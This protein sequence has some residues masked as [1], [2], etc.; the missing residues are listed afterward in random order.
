M[1]LDQTSDSSPGQFPRQGN[2][3]IEPVEPSTRTRNLP[4]L[5]F[6]GLLKRLTT[7]QIDH[8]VFTVRRIRHHDGRATRRD[9]GARRVRFGRRNFSEEL[10]ALT[11]E[12]IMGSIGV[13]A[14]G[15]TVWTVVGIGLAIFFSM[16]AMS[17]FVGMTVGLVAAL[18]WCLVVRIVLSYRGRPYS[19]MYGRG[20]GLQ[21]RC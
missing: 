14:A 12:P 20:A 16:Q 17:F 3:F 5:P 18:L 6:H 9:R 13:S 2:G 19:L 11:G 10:E 8:H 1:T 21:R 4:K 15:L 7:R